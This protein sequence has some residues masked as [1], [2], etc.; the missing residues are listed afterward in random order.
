MLTFPSDGARTSECGGGRFASTPEVLTALTKATT[1]DK[2]D[3]KGSH[4][5]SSG[6]AWVV[7]VPSSPVAAP[8]ITLGRRWD[9]AGS[10]LNQQVTR[11]D[12]LVP[13]LLGDLESVLVLLASILTPL[14]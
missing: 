5:P 8:R 12:S 6:I 2:F 13:A 4:T 9:N 1:S 10:F 7:R 11:L 3:P 14:G